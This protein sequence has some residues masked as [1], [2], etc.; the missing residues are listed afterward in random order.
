MIKT[1]QTLDMQGME[2]PTPLIWARNM[3]DLMDPGDNVEVLVTHT[4]AIR[5]FTL[6]ARSAGHELVSWS[7]CRGLIKILLKKGAV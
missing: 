1:M 7:E 3:L 6:F 2:G 5:D 4:G